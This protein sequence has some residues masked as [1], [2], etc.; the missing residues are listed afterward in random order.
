MLS[1]TCSKQSR[2]HDSTPGVASVACP[3]GTYCS[4]GATSALP[5]FLAISSAPARTWKLCLPIAM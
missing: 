1:T 2:A 3:S 5:S 4:T